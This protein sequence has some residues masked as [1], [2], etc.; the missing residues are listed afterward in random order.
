M[1]ITPCQIQDVLIIR[2]RWFSDARGEFSEVYSR[3]SWE[4]AGP[5]ADFC[6][7]NIARSPQA[8]TVRGLHFQSPP[9]AQAKLISVTRGAILD[10]VVDI[11]QGSP[12]FGQA[13]AVELSAENRL[14]LF[15]PHGFAHGYCTLSEETEV[16]YKVDGFYTP[17]AEGGLAWND[18]DL[19]LSWPSLANPALVN[20]RDRSWPRFRDFDSP[21]RYETAQP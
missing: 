3:R 21:F 14:Q 19:A 17:A 5:S 10:V 1:D 7:D 12:W 18:P 4:N 16:F 9:A 15:V 8:G 20:E 11:R 6:Q 13:V 2:P